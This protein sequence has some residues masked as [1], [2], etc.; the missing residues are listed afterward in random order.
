[1]TRRP[2][3]EASSLND[4]LHLA[5]PLFCNQALLAYGRDEVVA[6]FLTCADDAVALAGSDAVTM[7][8]VSTTELLQASIG[9]PAHASAV[10]SQLPKAVSLEGVSAQLLRRGVEAGDAAGVRVH[11]GHARGED[12]LLFAQLVKLGFS[13]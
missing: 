10:L 1:M 13:V 5:N 12:G 2:S 7:L 6:A 4:A 8:K 3:C 11:A 9:Y